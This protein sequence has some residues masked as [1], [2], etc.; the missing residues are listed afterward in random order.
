[1][2]I[3]SNGMPPNIRRPDRLAEFQLANR[4][5]GSTAGD[6]FLLRVRTSPSL[7]TSRSKTSIRP[8][9]QNMEI[10]F[11]L[12][13]SSLTG[14]DRTGSLSV[15]LRT[16][17]STRSNSIISPILLLGPFL[18]TVFGGTGAWA[19]RDA[20]ANSTS[21]RT[22]AVPA[23]AEAPEYQAQMA[24]D[25]ATQTLTTTMYQ[26]MAGGSLCV[27]IDSGLTPLDLT[28]FNFGTPNDGFYD[29]S[30]PFSVNTLSIMAYND[31]FTT[32]GDTSLVGDITY[33]SIAV[34][35]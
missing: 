22:R 7:P 25:G 10:S 6:N 21:S 3:N 34:I 33:Q 4:P 28:N 15:H 30:H 35:P 2:P 17:P 9:D 18:R 16:T 24:Y 19:S 13:N 20:F 27:Q 11:G 14:G 8:N 31:G 26:V 5:L 32:S 29:A 12:T 1:M 23:L